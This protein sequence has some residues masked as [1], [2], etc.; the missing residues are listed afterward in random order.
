MKQYGI[1]IKGKKGNVET[2]VDVFHLPL[3]YMDW[4][5][6]SGSDEL[7]DHATIRYLL[8]QYVIRVVDNGVEVPTDSL[9]KMEVSVIEKVITNLIETS[10]FHKPESFYELIESLDKKSKTLSGC[11]DLFIFQQLGVESYLQ[12][13]ERDAYTR[14]QIIMMIEKSTGINVKA[15]FDE[16]VSKGIPLDLI[17][18]PEQYRKGMKQRGFSKPMERARKSPLDAHKDAFGDVQKP[19]REDMPSNI[20]SMLQESRDSLAAAL[21]AGK[22]KS[23]GKKPTFDWTKDQGA[24]DQFDSE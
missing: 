11:Y 15:R 23:S 16:A 3:S 19:P 1:R 4:A 14:A 18:T 2:H 5:V 10:I 22:R 21:Q 9:L 24:F 12:L 13:I 8:Y 6:Y 20:D 17:S 7:F